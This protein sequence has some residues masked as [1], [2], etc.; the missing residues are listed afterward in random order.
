M[1]EREEGDGRTVVGDVLPHAVGYAEISTLFGM[2]YDELRAEHAA[3]SAPG[4]LA[5]AF[6]LGSALITSKLWTKTRPDAI[7]AITVGRHRECDVCLPKDPSISLRHL[8]VVAHPFD[9]AGD[10]HVS[11]RILDLRTNLAFADCFGQRMQ[12]VIADGAAI[13][14]IGRY[15]LLLLPTGDG[16]RLPESSDVGFSSIADPVYLDPQGRR[17][18]VSGITELRPEGQGQAPANT[19]D[20]AHDDGGMHRT[21]LSVIEGP[22]RAS[23]GLLGSAEEP[24]GTLEIS[25]EGH[26]RKLVVGGRAASQ[27]LLLGCYDRCD[28]DRLSHL[29]HHSIS[30]VHLLIWLHGETLYAIDTASTNGTF[31]HRDRKRVRARLIRLA[32]GLE[33]VLADD[34][35][36]LIWRSLD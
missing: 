36:R 27:G 5:I 6:D 12:G 25:A 23:A 30:R 26:S 3:R 19:N 8:A 33:V 20:S 35:A 22:T 11:F 1:I 21:S 15:V 24:L 14:T 9:P 4:L 10:R 28:D 18:V 32:N 31:V 2:H 17:P 7:N 16:T 29:K 13:F 34:R